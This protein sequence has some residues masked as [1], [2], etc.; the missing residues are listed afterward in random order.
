VISL[1]LSVALVL[2]LLV[3]AAV[4]TVRARRALA[5]FEAVPAN[6]IRYYRRFIAMGWFR[7]AVATLVAFTAG[8]SLTEIGV[9]GPGGGPIGG[10]PDGGMLAWLAALVMSV[11]MGIGAVRA[12]NRMRAGHLYPQ[13]ARIAALIP[14]TAGER[15][16]AVAFSVTAGI[17]EEIVFRGVLIALGI[18][19]FHLSV[20]A[21]AGLSLVFFAACHAYQGRLGVLSSGFLGLWFTGLTLLGGSILPA[22][23]MHIA[24]D[25]WAL[26]VVPAEPTPRPAAAEQLA[27]NAEGVPAD[28]A[29]RAAPPS[30]ERHENAPLAVPAIRPPTPAG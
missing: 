2:L 25:L 10:A 7:A 8:L 13:R 6:R 9:S 15:W 3:D 19:V 18:E 12:R 17:T 20:P 24:A 5:T 22:I 4:G 29:G 30:E 1:T 11:S 27:E 26:L 28:A 21:A 23:V 16:Y 14:R